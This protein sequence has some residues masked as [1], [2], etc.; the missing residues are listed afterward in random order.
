MKPVKVDAM[1]FWPLRLRY[2]L[3][4]IKLEQAEALKK[5]I[6]SAFVTFK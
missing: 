6:P 4:A 1:E 3:D 5:P 2:L